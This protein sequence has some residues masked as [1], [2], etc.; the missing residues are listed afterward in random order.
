M[1]CRLCKSNRLSFF[2]D[3][4]RQPLA[5][6]YPKNNNEI[7]KEK[8]FKLELLFCNSCKSLQIKKIIS[9]KYMFEDYYYLSSIN[10]GLVDHFKN[11]SKKFN[12]KSFVL[13]IGSNDGI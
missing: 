6:K 1:K 10:K 8:L 2:L 7:K 13:D 5:N 12:K 11:L 3:L 4:G 9:R